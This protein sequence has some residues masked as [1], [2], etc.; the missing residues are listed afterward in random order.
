MNL[1]CAQFEILLADHIDGVLA[2]DVAVAFDAHRESCSACAVLAADSASVVAFIDHAA[3][4][5]PPAELVG[6]I[7]RQTRIQHWELRERKPGVRGLVGRWASG[8]FAPHCSHRASRWELLMTLM[9]LALLGRGIS[10]KN[11]LTAADMNPAQI[12]NVLDGRTHRVWERTVMRYES[13]RLVYE[14]RNQI[15]DWTEQQQEM[16][17]VVTPAD[18]RTNGR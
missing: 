10:A 1:T 8:L 3:D 18:L 13:T 9:S 16:S 17:Q 7:L 6:E 5:E 12:W 15:D 14:V 11:T 4:V 2:S